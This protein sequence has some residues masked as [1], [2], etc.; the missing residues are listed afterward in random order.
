MLVRKITRSAFISIS[1]FISNDSFSQA[2]P[3]YEIG[4]NA[5]MYMYQ[6][7]LTLHRLGS[8]ETIRPGIGISGTRILNTSFSLRAMF[9]V[10]GLAADESIY[11]YPECR[12]ERNFSYA[13]SVKEAGL[14][15]H[16]NVLGTNY[17]DVKYEPYVFAGA[18]V[19]VINTNSNYSRVNWTYFG[20]QS[21]VGA[22]LAVD[23]TKPS[24]KIIPVVPVG[25]GVRYHISNRIVLNLE[26]TYRLMHTDYID[27]FSK[28]ANPKLGDHYSSLT[29][30]ASYKFKSKEKLGCRVNAM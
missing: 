15:F 4:L 26:E 9:L 22:G 25:A 24:Q 12:Q 20:E 21:D 10:A 28:S 7:D 30:G 27:G 8:I 14:S 17:Y 3:R 23:I 16:W 11:K 29:I 5:G 18:A 1:F 13:A 19:S 2:V 6:G